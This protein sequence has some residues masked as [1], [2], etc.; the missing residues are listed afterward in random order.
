MPTASATTQSPQTEISRF[1]ANCPE[2]A[3][4]LR[5]FCL[6]KLSMDSG[7][8]SAPLSLPR[9]SRFPTAG[10]GVDGDSVRRMLGQCDGRP[11]AAMNAAARRRCA[12]P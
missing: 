2:L 1:I 10:T 8:V 5:A 11:T 6:C 9:K 4:I 12:A 3:G 7:A